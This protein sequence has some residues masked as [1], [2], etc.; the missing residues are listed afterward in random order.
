MPWLIE[1]KRPKGWWDNKIRVM[2]E[3]RKYKTRTA[4]S[5]GSYSALKVAKQMVCIEEMT[6]FKSTQKV[7]KSDNI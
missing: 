6:W 4:F 7:L 2:E 3:G 1:K 5:K